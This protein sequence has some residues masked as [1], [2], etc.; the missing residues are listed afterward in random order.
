MYFLSLLQVIETN[1]RASRSFPFVSKTIGKDFIAVAT[2]VMTDT[3]L[4]DEDKRALDS[5]LLPKGYVGIKVN[6]DFNYVS[7]NMF[8][9]LHT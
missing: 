4:V 9:S 8:C 1:L 7:I 5:P 6:K 3:P 2:K